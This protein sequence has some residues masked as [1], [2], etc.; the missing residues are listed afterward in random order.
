MTSARQSGGPCVTATSPCR[1]PHGPGPR[2][3][4][5]SHHSVSASRGRG[6]SNSDSSRVL[7][8]GLLISSHEKPRTF[9]VIGARVW[10][11]AH[12][13]KGDL[14]GDKASEPARIGLG[15]R[16]SSEFVMAPVGVDGGEQDRVRR[17][18]VAVEE[19]LGSMVDSAP[20]PRWRTQSPAPPRRG[21]AATRCPMRRFS[22]GGAHS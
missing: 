22:P 4:A 10:A 8:S 9:F 13:Q 14:T 6:A 15:Q 3:R 12:M 17:D 5:A 1:Q 16:L 11:S 7:A 21:G 20:R 18:Q 19:P 2:V